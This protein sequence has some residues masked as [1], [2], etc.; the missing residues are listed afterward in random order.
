MVVSVEA[1]VLSQLFMLRFVPY[2]NVHTLNTMRVGGLLTA[3]VNGLYAIFVLLHYKDHPASQCL[4]YS[5]ID[6]SG[7]NSESVSRLVN[8]YT[9]FFGLIGAN[10]F[11]ITLGKSWTRRCYSVLP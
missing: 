8:S 11:T 1:V 9:S 5:G 7:S 6:T 4:T 10:I 3:A 2:S